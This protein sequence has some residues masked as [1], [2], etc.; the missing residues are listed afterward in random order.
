[1]FIA[2]YIVRLSIVQNDYLSIIFEY[3]VWEKKFTMTLSNTIQKLPVRALLLYIS[4]YTF[5][6][7]Y[8]KCKQE[9]ARVWRKHY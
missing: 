8:F 9:C 2:Y 4:S 6:Y 7:I 1:M 3:V 5:L